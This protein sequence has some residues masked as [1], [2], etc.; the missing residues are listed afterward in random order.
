MLH[1]SYTLSPNTL[2]SST[3]GSI[4]LAHNPEHHSR[5]KHIDIQYHFIRQHVAN[6]TIKLHF[7][8]TEGMIA[9][10]FTKALD[11]IE[12]ERGARRLGMSGSSSRGGVSELA[13]TAQ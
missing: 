5:T 12:Y 7:V 1:F 9:D 3:Q 8:G 10:T 13:E 11:R 6:K 4:A 2:L